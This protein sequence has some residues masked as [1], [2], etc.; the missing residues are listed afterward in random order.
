MYP[1][2][3]PAMIAYLCLTTKSILVG[4]HTN[5]GFSQETDSL[6]KTTFIL[7]HSGGF[8]LGKADREH[9]HLVR[10]FIYSNPGPFTYPWRN[11]ERL[12]TYLILLL[13]SLQSPQRLEDWPAHPN[14]NQSNLLGC[15]STARHVVGTH[16]N[17]QI[18][19]LLRWSG[20]CEPRSYNSKKGK[21]KCKKKCKSMTLLP[22]CYKKLI[23]LWTT[24][25]LV[26]RN[27][28]WLV[29][30]DLIFLSKWMRNSKI[31]DKKAGV[32]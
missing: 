2:F 12:Q 32:V 30:R 6:T 17:T 21:G 19:W 18:H 10:H 11:T 15:N 31:S 22:L 9:F 20:Q 16:H 24:S 8:C 1:L 14:K 7:E 4:T 13:M 5:Q 26:L 27:W 28:Q 3:K 25:R 23:L 29:L